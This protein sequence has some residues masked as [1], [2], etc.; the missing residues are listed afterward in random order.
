MAFCTNCGQPIPDQLGY[1]PNCTDAASD[2]DDKN[3]HALIGSILIG[4]IIILIAVVIDLCIVKGFI[5]G[6]SD[7]FDYETMPVETTTTSNQPS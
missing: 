7:S 3:K 6:S 1:C 5:G 2:A 4:V